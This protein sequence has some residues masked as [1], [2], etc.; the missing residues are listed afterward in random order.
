MLHLLEGPVKGHIT[1]DR[2]KKA[3]HP[4]RIDPQLRGVDSTAVLQALQ[5]KILWK[6]LVSFS[7]QLLLKWLALHLTSFYRWYG[8][9]RTRDCRDAEHRGGALDFRRRRR[10]RWRRD[11]SCIERTWRRR[12]RKTP[13]WGLQGRTCPE[14]SGFPAGPWSDRT[15]LCEWRWCGEPGGWSTRSV[16]GAPEPKVKTWLYFLTFCKKMRKNWEREELK[17]R[18][19]SIGPR[20]LKKWKR[21]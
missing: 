3:H 6:Q 20:K 4:A 16:G 19:F 2:K 7:S 18:N 14:G 10:R 17:E 11:R 8:Q 12:R 15:R 13:R 5:V 1:K 9:C 21:I